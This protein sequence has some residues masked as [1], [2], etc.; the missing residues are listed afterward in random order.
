MTRPDWDTT[1]LE[2]A[3]ILAGRSLC[4]GGAGAV[5]VAADNHSAFPGYAGPPWTQRT[6]DLTSCTQF[7]ERHRKPVEQRD[8]GY[9]DCQSIHAEM[10]ALIGADR[11]LIVGG[12][13]YIS[14]EPCWTCT[15]MIRNS[16]VRRYVYPVGPNGPDDT[17]FNREVRPDGNGDWE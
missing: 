15:K 5:V 3:G 2:I 8:P 4:Q 6:A 11:T 12:T 14:R 17:M 7:C 13:F 10:N 1:W 9:M 16:G